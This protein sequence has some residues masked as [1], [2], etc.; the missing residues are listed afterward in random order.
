MQAAKAELAPE[1]RAIER[2]TRKAT[3]MAIAAAAETSFADKVETER[4]LAPDLEP[5]LR[6]RGCRCPAANI[7]AYHEEER[8]GLP[9]LWAPA[10]ATRSQSAHT[11]NAKASRRPACPAADSASPQTIDPT[12]CPPNDPARARPINARVLIYG[13]SGELVAHA[14]RPARRPV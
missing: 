6:G 1:R 9:H 3:A 2:I 12:P 13:S 7:K 10:I 14:R 5:H 8:V 11:G 4:D